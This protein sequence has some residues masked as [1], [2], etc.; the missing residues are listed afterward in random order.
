MNALRPIR[1]FRPLVEL[2]E[3]RVDLVKNM[4]SSHSLREN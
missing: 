1:Y 4:E 3:D 2:L